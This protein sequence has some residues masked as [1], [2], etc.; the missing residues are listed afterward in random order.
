MN[1]LEK[2]DYIYLER[3]TKRIMIVKYLGDKCVKCGNSNI[4]VLDCHHR[5]P[6]EKEMSIS[7]LVSGRWSKIEKEI[8]KCIL[9]CRNCHNDIHFHCNNIDER[10]LNLKNKLLDL[11]GKKCCLECGHSSIS[12][13][14]FHHTK[15][16]QFDMANIISR[17]LSMPWDKILLE[18]DKCIVLCRNCHA[19]KHFDKDKFEKFKDIIFKKIKEYKEPQEPI[20]VIM[21]K[22][23]RK[24][25]LSYSQ[26]AKRLGRTKS[27]VA[28]VFYRERLNSILK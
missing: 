15:E 17:K 20:D 11:K 7:K 5:N 8:K 9:L 4:F 25:G 16:K 1:V 14:E 27:I 2:K 3:I 21:V 6:I 23:L 19:L 26:I 18:L 13:L 24:E 12:S 22:N 28:N 10:S